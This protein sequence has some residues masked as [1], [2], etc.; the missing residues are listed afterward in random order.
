[1][2]IV[3]ANP[4]YVPVTGDSGTEKNRRAALRDALKNNDW[5]ISQKLVRFEYR[6]DAWYAFQEGADGAPVRLERVG[7]RTTKKKAKAT[8]KKRP[9]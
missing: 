4:E 5:P 7:S 6:N 9:G 8:K 3:P 1:M 2:A